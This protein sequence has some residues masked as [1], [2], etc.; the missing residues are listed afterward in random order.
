MSRDKGAF[1]CR[2]M[3]TAAGIAFALSGSVPV[4]SCWL[5]RPGRRANRFRLI[6]LT[7]DTARDMLDV[8]KLMGLCVS[9]EGAG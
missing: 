5:K 6:Q 4:W 8:A 3:M 7:E 2:L 1:L 9:N